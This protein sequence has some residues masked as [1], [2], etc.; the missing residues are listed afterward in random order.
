ML[1]LLFQDLLDGS[2]Q[3]SRECTNEDSDSGVAY[4]QIRAVYPKMTKEEMEHT[5]VEKL[6]QHSNIACLGTTHDI[7]SDD[8][9]IFYKKLQRYVDSREKTGS[10]KD[11]T[12]KEKKKP[13]EMEFWPLI[14][15]VRLHVKAAALAT[16]AVI[17]D[18]PVSFLPSISSCHITRASSP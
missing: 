1:K 13:R 12:D 17:V 3:V 6:M 5:T 8:S 14:R 16:G 4:A 7:E 15:V 9:L 18:L 11:R 10:S 2:G